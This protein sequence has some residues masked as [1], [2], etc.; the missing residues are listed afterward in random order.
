[1]GMSS[2][3]EDDDGLMDTKLSGLDNNNLSPPKHSPASDSGVNLSSINSS[4]NSN[5]NVLSP[6][7]DPGLNIKDESRDSMPSSPESEKDC[8]DGL[9]DGMDK[10]GKDY[11]DLDGKHGKGDGEGGKRRGPRTTIKAKQLET[12]KSAFNATP[13]PTRHIREQL[14]QDTGLN[15]RVIQ[16]R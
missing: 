9:L 14:A 11:K 3:E 13:K 7:F 15:M 5:G 10:D 6:S 12:L 4:M 1:M 16:V 8:K 2:D